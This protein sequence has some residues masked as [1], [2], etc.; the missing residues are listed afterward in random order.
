M[1]DMLISKPLLVSWI[2]G[3]DP[4]EL[5]FPRITNKINVYSASVA[6]IQIQLYQN[7]GYKWLVCP[8]N[9][10]LNSLNFFHF[11][12]TESQKS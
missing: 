11:P 8:C 12:F 6:L 7:M 2:K 1:N 5:C 4:L 9:S 10:F 3:T